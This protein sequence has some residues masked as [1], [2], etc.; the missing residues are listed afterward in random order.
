MKSTLVRNIGG[1]IMG[2]VGGFLVNRWITC[3]SG[4]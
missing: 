1:P 2:A 4:G 3:T